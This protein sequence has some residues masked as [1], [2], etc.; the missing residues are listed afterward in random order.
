MSANR[1]FGTETRHL[2]NDV[3]GVS[4]DLRAN[5]DQLFLER[6][7]RPVLDR[8]RRRQRAQEVAEVVGEGVKLKARGVG[9]KR[10]ARQPRPVDRTLARCLNQGAVPPSSLAMIDLVTVS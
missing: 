8:L 9:G 4:G 3:A 1:A 6:R 5:P 10:P 2:E 7:H